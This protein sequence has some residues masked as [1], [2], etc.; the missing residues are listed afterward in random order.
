[1]PKH[2]MFGN[3]PAGTVRLAHSLVTRAD[4]G[5]SDYTDMTMYE[6]PLGAI[7]FATGTIQWSWGVDDF[8]SAGRGSR[9]TAAAQQITR[10]VLN[11]FINGKP[12]PY[13][14]C[15]SVRR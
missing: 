9:Q 14:K 12:V 1:M 11:A 6:T 2:K 13:A 8:N 15:R 7:V 4:T 3:A 5:A 10:N